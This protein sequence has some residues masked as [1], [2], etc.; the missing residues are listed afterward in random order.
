MAYAPGDVRQGLVV[1]TK[2]IKQAAELFDV[3]RHRHARKGSD[4]VIVRTDI[5]L[6]DDTAQELE[7][8]GSDRFLFGE[9]FNLWGRK[10][11]RKAAR[12]AT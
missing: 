8:S 1:V 7:S 5:I 10:R 6:R 3:R 12:V 11:A 2:T 9:S 4:F